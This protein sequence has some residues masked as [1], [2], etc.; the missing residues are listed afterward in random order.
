MDAMS[1]E[2]TSFRELIARVRSGDESAA[3][4][5]MRRYEPAIRRAIRVR[6]VDTR[7]RRV[8][9]S[10]D[11]AQSVFASFFV[12]AAL[13]QYEL[14]KPVQ[15]LRLL[16]T[17]SQKKLTN[18]V[19]EEGAARRDFRRLRGRDQGEK[20]FVDLV[21]GPGQQVAA[22][23]LLQEFRKRFSEEERQLADWRSMDRS[24]DEIAAERCESPE[25]LRK[26]LARAV[27]RI[28]QELG[29]V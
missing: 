16:V 1:E 21:P 10:E 11:V 9:D 27:E 28:S 2:P 13:G 7:L 14:E 8:F 23:E 3:A 20:N 26:R 25:A 29:L 18:H 12:R 22:K 4:D 5:L 17:M 6:M 19:R 24:W 15:L